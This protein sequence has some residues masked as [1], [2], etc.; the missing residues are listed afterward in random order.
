MDA[1]RAR[2][3]PAGE[4]QRPLSYKA[5][6]GPRRR[7][8]NGT[9]RARLP[10]SRCRIAFDEGDVMQAAGVRVQSSRRIPADRAPSAAAPQAADAPTWWWKV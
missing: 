10:T 2:P 6:N 5:T 4:A 7:R 8:V 1:L 9:R 3:S